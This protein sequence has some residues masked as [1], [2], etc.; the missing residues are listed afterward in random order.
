MADEAK[1]FSWVKEGRQQMSE[2]FR[3]IRNELLPVAQREHDNAASTMGPMR[4][5]EF[6]HGSTEVFHWEAAAK[7]GDIVIHLF[8]VSLPESFP[9]GFEEIL[10]EVYEAE[11]PPGQEKL[12]IG[13][14][15]EVTPSWVHPERHPQ[16][17]PTYPSWCI[18]LRGYAELEH[19][20][21]RLVGDALDRIVELTLARR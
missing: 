20:H 6:I 17:L 14:A 2:S 15:P 9:D 21:Q 5:A 11:V 10:K 4:P 18:T 3:D 12:G 8:P 1:D 16:G 13:F 19:T 7:D